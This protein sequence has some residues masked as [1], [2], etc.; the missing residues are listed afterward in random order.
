MAFGLL[1]LSGSIS[2]QCVDTTNQW[3]IS[4][5]SLETGMKC[6]VHSYTGMQANTNIQSVS[7]LGEM[8][9]KFSKIKMFIL[10]TILSVHYFLSLIKV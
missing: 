1:V 3:Q 9:K 2:R 6:T 7:G 10:I 5:L 4:G 8:D